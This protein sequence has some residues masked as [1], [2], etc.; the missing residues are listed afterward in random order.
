[1]R[2]HI[3]GR[4]F[5]IALLLVL[6]INLRVDAD[7]MYRITALSERGP[8]LPFAAGMNNQG[9]VAGSY[10]NTPATQ[11][12]Y[13]YDSKT[14]NVTT[15]DAP[16]SATQP[17][18]SNPSI[19]VVTGINDSGQL[20]GRTNSADEDFGKGFLY[21]NGQYTQ[22]P[23]D[24][25][26]INNSGQVAGQAPFVNGQLTF[27]MPAA[28]PNSPSHAY[29]F[30][31][32]TIKD[33]GGVGDSTRTFVQ[34][35]NDLGQATGSVSFNQG[36]EPHVAFYDGQTLKDLG[37]LGG[38]YGWGSRINNHGDIV[39]QS[40]TA[41]GEWHAF[42]APQGGKLIDLGLLPRGTFSSSAAD[43]N[44]KGQIVGDSSGFFAP[45]NSH[46]FLYEDGV[47]TDLNRLIPPDSRVTL[48]GAF[49]INNAGQILAVGVEDG[50]DWQRLYLLS[51]DGQG[52]PIAPSASITPVPEPST[53][54]V[55][56]LGLAAFAWRSLSRRR[57]TVRPAA[58]GI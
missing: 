17:T 43:I 53:L 54:A 46:A 45:V 24:A 57:R 56:S 3:V 20:I 39:G 52:Q 6:G 10:Y 49:R 36:Q 25:N 42:L 32:G 55:Y 41:S 15:L 33:L 47:M 16:V 23:G 40:A 5:R 26:A 58:R 35:L 21:S 13:V 29:I 44:D 7:P 48:T 31:N 51:P 14:G 11:V 30:S 4:A 8:M 28:F 2:S 37:T 50:D 9:Q 22:I 38:P 18:P 19:T 1:M 34:A 12:G 27:D